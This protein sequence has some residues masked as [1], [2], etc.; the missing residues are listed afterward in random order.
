M[1]KHMDPCLAPGRGGPSTP[2]TELAHGPWPGNVLRRIRHR[3][4]VPPK[5]E[6]GATVEHMDPCL[7]PGRGGPSTHFTEL[8][9]GPWP[10]SYTHLTLPTKA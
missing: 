2:F 6:I 1:V 7:A 3:S 4:S 5:E 9:H 8:V 10:V